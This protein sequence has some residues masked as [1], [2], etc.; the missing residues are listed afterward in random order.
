MQI[1]IWNLQDFFVFLDKHP[2]NQALDISQLT[3]AQWQML[4]SSF[5]DN[6]ELVKVKAIADLINQQ[7]PQ[8]LLFTEVGGGESLNNF[9]QYFLEDNYQ[10]IH[11]DSNSDRGIDI[12]ALVQADLKLS[13]TIFHRDDVFARGVLELKLDIGSLSLCILLTHL[14]SKLN[15]DGSDFEGRKKREQEVLKLIHY[16]E[17]RIKQGQEVMVCGDLNGIIYEDES[18]HE[19]SHFAKK[20]GLKDVLSHL[21]LPDFDRATYLYY[22]KSQRMIPMQLDYCLVTEGLKSLLGKDTGVLDFTGKKRTNFPVSLKE[23]KV[24]PSDHYPLSVK[25]NLKPM[26]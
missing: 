11:F 9:N 25:L 4:S 22:N 3:E 26:T 12:A 2:D 16:A 14:K 6:K 17:R 7:K 10:V 5:K 1:L 24:H 15:K 18:E 21:Q 19:L 13:S 20:L 23:K 8:I